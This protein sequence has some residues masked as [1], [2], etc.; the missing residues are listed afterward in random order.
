MV[1]S[2]GSLGFHPVYLATAIGSGG[3][4]GAWMNDS[5]FC[6]FAKMGGF[7]EAETLKS[8]TILLA[9][10]GITGFVTTLILSII[11]PLA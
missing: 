10:T 3:K 4:V 8:W 11:L 5:A 7:T 2:S 9:V 6:I 1:P